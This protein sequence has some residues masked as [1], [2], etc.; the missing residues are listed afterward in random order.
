MLELKIQ[1]QDN[2]LFFQFP[3][4]DDWIYEFYLN[5]IVNSLNKGILQITNNGKKT[6][7]DYPD[8][9][10]F[11]EQF[12]QYNYNKELIQNIQLYENNQIVFDSSNLNLLFEHTSLQLNNLIEIDNIILDSNI[13]Y[14]NN[15]RM[16][17]VFYSNLL[18]EQ[19]E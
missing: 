15:F 5:N 6:L 14:D 4:K 1:L 11:N 2:I 7:I 12:K 18:N 16:I 8:I 19:E 9:I 13:N 17:I 10:N 3:I